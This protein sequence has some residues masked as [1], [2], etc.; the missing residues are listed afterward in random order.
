MLLG[1]MNGD[2]LSVYLGSTTLFFFLLSFVGVANCIF[3][4]LQTLQR[5]VSRNLGLLVLEEGLPYGSLFLVISL[6]LLYEVLK[7]YHQILYHTPCWRRFGVAVVGH[8]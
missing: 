8:A 7:A 2:F 4:L 3:I 6:S 1:F 5:G